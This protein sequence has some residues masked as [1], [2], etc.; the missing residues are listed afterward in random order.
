M[1]KINIREAKTKDLDLILKLNKK[2][3]IKEYNEFDNSLNLNWTYSKRGRE[4]FSERIKHDNGK[5]LIVEKENTVIGYLC[6]G[7]QEQEEEFYRKDGIYAELENMFLEEK[8]RNLGIGREIVK[9]FIT[10]CKKKEVN[11]INVTASFQNKKALK[12]Y[13][14]YGFNDYDT[15]LD[16]KL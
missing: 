14:K 6:G 7:I 5:V 8:F 15:K 10:W 3:F 13:R 1:N 9:L 2:L 12:F 11:H 16:L 4:Y